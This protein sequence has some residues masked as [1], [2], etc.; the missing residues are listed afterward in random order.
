MGCLLYASIRQ[1][2]SGHCFLGLNLAFSDICR[3]TGVSTKNVT[4]LLDA[5]FYKKYKKYKKSIKNKNQYKYKKVVRASRIG[6]H[7]L[8]LRW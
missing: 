2:I 1:D 6:L 3:K 8:N 7:P 5:H 4:G